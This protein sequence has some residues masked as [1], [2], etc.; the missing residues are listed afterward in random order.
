MQAGQGWNREEDSM[1]L[2]SWSP[3][4]AKTASPVRKT[5]F[6]VCFEKKKAVLKHLTVERHSDNHA[7]WLRVDRLHH[8]HRRPQLKSCVR[9]L[10]GGRFAPVLVPE[11][12]PFGTQSLRPR[13]LPPLPP[14]PLQSMATYILLTAAV[15]STTG[16]STLSSQALY[17]LLSG[18]LA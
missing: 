12:P 2:C 5:G 1:A 10:V 9:L 4:G 13:R 8:D 18:I 14:P 15:Y 3:C 17:A 11:R 7:W 6:S 16:C